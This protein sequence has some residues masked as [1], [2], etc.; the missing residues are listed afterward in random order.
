MEVGDGATRRD[1][2]RPIRLLESDAM[3]AVI[4]AWL[5]LAIA[6]CFA[7]DRRPRRI[8]GALLLLYGGSLFVYALVTGDADLGWNVSVAA[9]FTWLALSLRRAEFPPGD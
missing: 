4:L 8:L 2:V 5:V 6:L 7:E 9:L 3:E 1:A